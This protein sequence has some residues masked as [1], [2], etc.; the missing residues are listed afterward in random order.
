MDEFHKNKI[1]GIRKFV[2]IRD[3]ITSAKHPD[4]KPASKLISDQPIN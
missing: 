3:Q 2:L 1:R 4:H